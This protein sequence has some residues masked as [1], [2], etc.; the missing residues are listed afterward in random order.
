MLTIDTDFL[1]ILKKSSNQNYRYLIILYATEAQNNASDKW[2]F[3]AYGTGRWH[4]SDQYWQ[5]YDTVYAAYRQARGILVNIDIP[6]QEKIDIEDHTSSV[7]GFSIQLTDDGLINDLNNYWINNRIISLYL[8][9]EGLYSTG[10][11]LLVYSGVVKDYSINDYIITINIENS[12]YLK[13]KI[14]PQTIYESD[15]ITYSQ[16]PAEVKGS[17]IPI[18]YGDHPFYYGHDGVKTDIDNNLNKITSQENNM[19]KTHYL[20][21]DMDGYSCYL[22]CNHELK[23]SNQEY[24]R[25]WMFDSRLRRFVLINTSTCSYS[26]TSGKTILKIDTRTGLP[27]VSDF[28]FPDQTF[29]IVLETGTNT[30]P[31]Y[32]GKLIDGIK[33][34]NRIWTDYGYTKYAETTSTN[35]LIFTINFP[36]YDGYQDDADISE[37]KVFGL[38]DYDKSGTPG[39][40]AEINSTSI[41]GMNY[42]QINDLGTCADTRAGASADI[43]VVHSIVNPIITDYS[44]IKVYEIFKRITYTPHDLDDIY[45]ACQGRKAGSTLNTLFSSITS[46]D[47]LL[48]HPVHIIADILKNELLVSEM[49]ATKMQSIYNELTA[50]YKLAF[51]IQDGINSKELIDKIGK[52]SK[53]VT[54][55]DA[56][57]SFTMDKIDYISTI[58]RIIYINEI[59]LPQLSKTSLASVV[60]L[61]DLRY[62]KENRSNE[63]QL[64][65]AQRE[66]DRAN[67]GS[68]NVY[69]F[70]GYKILDSEYIADATTAGLLA[71]FH[72]KDDD[73]SFWSVQHNIIEFETKDFVGQNAWDGSDFKPLYSLELFDEIA[74]DPTGFDTVLKCFGAS[75]SGK[76]FKIIEITRNKTTLNIKA[77]EI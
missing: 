60:N 7:G 28:W 46:D 56:S 39:L 32:Q 2:G 8:I 43:E 64:K 12:T 68:Q 58:D 14:L 13:H 75:W 69:N 18:I 65:L 10:D 35:S 4:F 51:D 23:I 9:C 24:Y 25:T 40:V 54:F 26:Y 59:S 73:D 19:V 67:V 16:Q 71:D 55:V 76:V 48:E 33:T 57:N 62:K 30:P 42:T 34:C 17:R 63:Y 52:E 3:G 22:V 27:T 36:T 41:D 21:R 72:C 20:G 15:D 1:N 29:T 53:C 11:A 66:D 49:G 37:V 47:Q 44:E 77:I 74:L 5:V 38:I 45:I 70:E 31:E 6:I 61:F 50:N